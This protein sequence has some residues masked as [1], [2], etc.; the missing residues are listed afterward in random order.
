MFWVSWRRRSIAVWG[1]IYCRPLVLWH[2]THTHTHTKLPKNIKTL[3]ENASKTF[4]LWRHIDVQRADGSVAFGPFT[5]Y[6]N[7]SQRR[8]LDRPARIGY[9]YRCI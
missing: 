5:L 2:G 1:R 4:A 9:S 3:S 6:P 7:S 8:S